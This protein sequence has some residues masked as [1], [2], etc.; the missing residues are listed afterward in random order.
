MIF[1]HTKPSDLTDDSINILTI[2][3]HYIIKNYSSAVNFI[4]LILP[5][6][7]SLRFIISVANKSKGD[8]A[9]LQKEI[10]KRSI[11]E[12]LSDASKGKMIYEDSLLIFLQRIASMNVGHILAS[13]G[14]PRYNDTYLDDISSILEESSEYWG[15]L[16]VFYVKAL[17]YLHYEKMM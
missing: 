7:Y 9:M 4:R 16:Y 2:H 15:D 1:S 8:L 12:I 10:P 5:D 3:L 17:N 11:K 6:I 13:P 14:A